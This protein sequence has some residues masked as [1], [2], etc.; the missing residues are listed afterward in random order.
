MASFS[1]SKGSAQS[2]SAVPQQVLTAGSDM[3]ERPASVAPSSSSR[4]AAGSSS[5][6]WP[7][8]NA[9]AAGCRSAP[10]TGS[11][12]PSAPRSPARRGVLKYQLGMTSTR[13]K[14]PAALHVGVALHDG[15][16]LCARLRSS[17]S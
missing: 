12:S 1:S 16:F 14:T 4:C 7:L 2:K 10:G 3:R 6:R 9:G 8:R 15:S 17:T 13:S 11:G 5:R